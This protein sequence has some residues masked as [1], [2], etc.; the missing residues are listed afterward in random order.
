MAAGS[1]FVKKMK[2]AYWSEMASNA[3]KKWFS[4]IK[5]GRRQPFGIYTL[6]KLEILTFKTR[7]LNL[8]NRA[9]YYLEFKSR[10]LEFKSWDLEF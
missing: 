5:N 10:D 4:V 7:D 1:H 3:I 2:V 6:F 8:T 9:S